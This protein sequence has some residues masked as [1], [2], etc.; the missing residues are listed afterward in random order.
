MTQNASEKMLRA[1]LRD[2]D[3]QDQTYRMDIINN[4]VV[5]DQSGIRFEDDASVIWEFLREFYMQFKEAAHFDVAIQ[6][7]R[8]KKNDA[9]VDY[10]DLLRAYQ[11]CYRSE[12][13]ILV[14]DSLDV[15]KTRDCSTLLKRAAQILSTGLTIKKGKEE[16]MYKGYTDAVRHIMESAEYF[17]S[18]PTGSK[19]AGD[20]N[21][22]AE[23]L[24]EEFEHVVTNPGQTWGYACGLDPIDK[25]CRG[26][27]PGE[28]WIHAGSVGEMKT[29]FAMNWAYK[30]A[31]I[32]GH[33]VFY[34]SL[35]MPYAQIRRM[36]AVM[37][38]ANPKFVKQ[39]Y[40]ILS[41]QAIRDGIN[42]DGSP[43]SAEVI[44]Y[45]DFLLEDIDKNRDYGRLHIEVPTERVSI[46][47]MKHKMEIYHQQNPIQMAVI[48]HLLLVKPKKITSNP[49]MDL[50]TVMRDAKLLAMH[51]NGGERLPVLGLLQINRKGKEE[52]DKNDGRYKTQALADANEAERSADVISYTY[53][54]DELRQAKQVKIG[55]LKNR[56]NPHFTPFTASVDWGPRYIG[57]HFDQDGIMPDI[58]ALELL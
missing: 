53:L 9:C 57:H 15:Q 27:K 34:Y 29:S 25:V 16:T 11:P 21:D 18:A 4:Y 6:Y 13:Q 20:L 46:S 23:E 52:A 33:N 26:L 10:L 47:E 40:P 51:F 38:S 17:L 44:E 12:F 45:Y 5:M 39:G 3:P 49:Y 58:N 30:Q 14:R 7:F 32:F 22:D 42:P 28:L 2:G 48:D 54:N 8:D 43:I 1:L 36:F 55:C 19:N 50:N 24:R 37:H 41:Y 56:E 35:E 31:F